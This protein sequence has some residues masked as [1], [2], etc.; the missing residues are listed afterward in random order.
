M[1]LIVNE[2]FFH[3][4]IIFTQYVQVAKSHFYQYL[5]ELIAHIEQIKLKILHL[6]YNV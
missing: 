2:I 1:H 5:Q 4:L 6:C 3:N